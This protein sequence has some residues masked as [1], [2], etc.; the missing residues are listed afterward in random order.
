MLAVT[1]LGLFFGVMVAMARWLI[2]PIVDRVSQIPTVI[3]ESWGQGPKGR[4][5]SA[6]R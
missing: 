4:K 2:E 3:R 6:T 1:T 5:K